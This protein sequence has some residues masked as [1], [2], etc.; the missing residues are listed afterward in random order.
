MLRGADMAYP[1]PRKLWRIYRAFA[2]ADGASK[3]D[4]VV[5]RAAFEAGMLATVKLF[6]VMIESGET[7]AMVAGIRRTGRDLRALES[8][9][10]H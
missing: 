6:S 2:V 3:R 4:V 1:S 7:K 9:L 10:W 8:T 5:A